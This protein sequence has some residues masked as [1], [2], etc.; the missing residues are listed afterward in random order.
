MRSQKG[1][2]E[3]IKAYLDDLFAGVGESQQLFDLKEELAIN[4]REKIGDYEKTGMSQ[5]EAFKAA[6]SSM[7]DLSG[8]VDDM[9]EAGRDKARQNVYTS[10]SE[11]ISTAGLI[12]GILIILFGALTTAMIWFMGLQL[13][14]VMGPVIF[15]V[16]GGAIL[17]YSLL[18]RET[19]KKY[20]M[21]RVRAILYS[22]SAG[23]L[24][25]SLY[26][27]F[28]SGFATG[29]VFIGISTFMVFFLIGIGLLLG[30]LFTG[31][32]RRK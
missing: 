21:N 6:V 12:V 32:D 29:E 5:E 24:L 23:L 14:A 30:L 3:K 16:F 10:M 7:G 26:V 13:E 15:I 22:L 8:L 1:L 17:T 31:S 18:T 25:F 20:A 28:T 9:R 4:L 11:R 2:N 27:G 19:R